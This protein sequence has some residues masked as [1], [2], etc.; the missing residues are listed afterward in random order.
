M[1]KVVSSNDAAAIAAQE[2]VLIHIR[3]APNGSVLFIDRCPATMTAQ[4]WR[5]YLLTE[6]GSYYQT[7]TGARGF[8]RL[9]RAVYDSLVAKVLPL[10][11][12]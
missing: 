12:E 11:A 10:A 8:L 6:A 3:H 5:D 7:F 1:L 9:P 4:Q 2:E